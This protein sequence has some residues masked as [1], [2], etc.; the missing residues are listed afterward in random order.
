[1]QC[2][3]EIMGSPP[4]SL[5]EKATRKEHFFEADGTVKLSAN[6]AGLRRFPASKDLNQVLH[7]N[8]GPFLSF[9]QVGNCLSMHLLQLLDLLWLHTLQRA[10]L[11]IP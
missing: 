3:M 4:A 2:V 1:M 10:T 6:K 8:D 9:L 11:N 7:C 5:M